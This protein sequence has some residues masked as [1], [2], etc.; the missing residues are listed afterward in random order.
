VVSLTNSNGVDNERWTQARKLLLDFY[1]SEIT[2]HSRL[3]IGFAALLFT[4][5]DIYGLEPRS[6]LQSTVFCIVVFFLAAALWYV[7]LR[8]IAYG[9]MANSII[10]VRDPFLEKIAQQKENNGR[11]LCSIL[12]IGIRDR[13]E[14]KEEIW[15]RANKEGLLKKKFKYKILYLIPIRYFVSDLF[16][17]RKFGFLLCFI[18]GIITMISMLFLLGTLP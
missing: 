8:L 2:A 9:I 11:P 5:S 6:V 3:I 14:G 7:F 16:E 12:G 13:V 18:L 17:D 1:S 4:A 10:H 15:I